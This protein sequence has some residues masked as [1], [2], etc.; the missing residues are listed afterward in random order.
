MTNL[1]HFLYLVLSLSILLAA[2]IVGPFFLKPHRL[3]EQARLVEVKRAIDGD[4]IELV[5]GQRVRYI[6]IDTPEL[7][8]RDCYSSEAAERNK[9]LVVGKFVRL[10][11]DVSETDKYGRLLRYVYAVDKKNKTEIFV[12]EQLINEGFAL[13]LT[14]PPD[15]AFA[16]KFVEEE[17]QARKHKIGLWSICGLQTVEEEVLEIIR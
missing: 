10:E 2:T 15:V 12:N 9:E 16:E 4:T 13:T 1:R 3:G 17:R 7:D 8:K 5:G 11:K 6:G 14:L